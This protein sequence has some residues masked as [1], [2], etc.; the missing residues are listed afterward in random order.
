MSH[1]ECL[2]ELFYWRHLATRQILDIAQMEAKVRA[3]SEELEV[4]RERVSRVSSENERL[5]RENAEYSAKSL[6]KKQQPC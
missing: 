2:E 4:A 3:L 6:K 1:E 5:E